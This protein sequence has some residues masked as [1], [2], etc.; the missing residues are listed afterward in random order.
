MSTTEQ[1]HIQKYR[2]L[3][4]YGKEA[5][6]GV[7]DVESRRCEAVRT[8]ALREDRKQMEA[9][10]ETELDESYSMP[11]YSLPMSAGT[12]QPAGGRISRGFSIDY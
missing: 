9:A 5:V 11:M 7:L 2:L 3:D 6:D 1:A 8:A 12:G 10:E 4:D